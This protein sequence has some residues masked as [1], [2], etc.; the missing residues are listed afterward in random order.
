MDLSPESLRDA[1]HRVDLDGW[2]GIAGRQLLDHVR[3]AVVVPVVRRS[4]L[5]GPAADQAEASSWAA[6]WDALRRPTARTAQNP[7]GMVWAAVRR[8]VAAEVEFSRMSEGGPVGA[9][10]Q[11]A[12]AGVPGESGESGEAARGLA[13][14]STQR[15]HCAA[16]ALVAA[17]ERRTRCLSLDDLMDGGWQPVDTGFGI[18]ED[19]EPVV[20]AVLDGLVA[21]GWDRAVAADSIALMADHAAR[22]PYGSPTTRWRWVALR[23]GVP[24][25]QARRLAGLL[26]GGS[27]WPG[28]LELVVRHGAAVIGDPAVQGAV[29]STTSRWSAGPSAWLASWDAQLE[30]IA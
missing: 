11:G 7:G 2:D 24:E 8:A 19:L 28:V 14:A 30:G 12:V 18:P 5:R 21:A 4:G 25:W 17:Q 26:L 29:R 23:I 20:G 13:A 22:A 9:R 10:T 3:R 1:L 6:A 16:L 27:G 15:P